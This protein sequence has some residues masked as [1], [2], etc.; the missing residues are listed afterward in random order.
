MA[1]KKQPVE[2]TKMTKRKVKTER[3]RRRWQA[4][5]RRR[6]LLGF[7]DVP[8]ADRPRLATRPTPVCLSLRAVEGW[9]VPRALRERL[10]GGQAT[11]ACALSLSFFDCASRRF[12][13]GTWMGR[14]REP[15]GAG[16]SGLAV[17]SCELV[18][19]CT[20]VDDAA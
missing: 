19:W 7:D 2:E 4:F 20:R 18:H 3:R 10:A 11:L 15:E 5:Q 1:K 6:R 14:A 9:A 12:F 8:R 13:G 16:S 17:R